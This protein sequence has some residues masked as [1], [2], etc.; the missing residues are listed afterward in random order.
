MHT[1]I[2]AEVT[3]ECFGGETTLDEFVGEL[4]RAGAGTGE[5]EGGVDIFHF[6]YARK[7]GE[8]VTF[9]DDIETL[10]DG[11]YGEFFGFDG[12]CLRIFEVFLRK[13]ANGFGECGGEERGLARGRGLLEDAFDI[14]YEA[15]G[16]H[17]VCFVEDEVAKVGKIKCFLFFDEV[18]E[19]TGGANDDVE[20]IS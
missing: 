11:V 5:D 9:V 17:F 20:A 7:S 1:S 6:N 4:T 15:H 18:D 13:Y 8:F 3:I 2:L 12:D 19:T 14:V 10:F 16:K